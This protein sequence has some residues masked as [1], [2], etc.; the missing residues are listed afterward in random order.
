LLEIAPPEV[1]CG[2]KVDVVV[3][4]DQS[5][6]SSAR[7]KYMR[8]ILPEIVKQFDMGPDKIH[9]S[10]VTFNE[11]AYTEF[12]L[13]DYADRNK[14]AN[15]IKKVDYR[16]GDHNF[17]AA[18]SKARTEMSSKVTARADACKV[19]VMV[20]FCGG[21]DVMKQLAVREALKTKS[22]GVKII[23]VSLSS[24]CTRSMMRQMA[25]EP[26][27]STVFFFESPAEMLV[28][29]DE[30]V[31]AICLTTCVPATNF[32]EA[33]TT[34]ATTTTTALPAPAATTTT[35]VAP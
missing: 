1:R 9:L 12:N 16:G 34:T 28:G 17:A 23:M 2:E 26:T 33:A 10:V 4:L 6:E 35:T 19:L 27:D 18:F 8:Q 24:K 31:D 14:V 20:T 32:T 22:M 29:A 7:W 5:S 13:Y 11:R 25:S 30:L 21:K 15:A 3:A